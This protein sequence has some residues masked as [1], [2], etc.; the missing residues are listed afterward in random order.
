MRGGGGED[1]SW[2]AAALV[3]AGC[4]GW[5]G[6]AGRVLYHRSAAAAAAATRRT[7]GLI[8]EAWRVCVCR[9]SGLVGF[10]GELPSYCTRIPPAEQP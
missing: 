4:E 5:V 7:V 6:S 10:V 3:A 2:P 1:E 8:D 9:P